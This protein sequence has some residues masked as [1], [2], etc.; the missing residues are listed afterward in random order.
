M[1]TMKQP[2]RIAQGHWCDLAAPAKINTFLHVI[3]KRGDGMHLLQSIFMM[4]DWGDYVDIEVTNASC[5]A[6]TDHANTAL[7]LPANDLC[8]QAATLL[9]Q[10]T[11]TTLGARIAL[12]K[13]LPAQAGLGG[14]SSDAAT[15]LLALNQLWHTGLNTDQLC[16]LAVQLG[17]DVPFF[18][19]GHNA[20]VQGIGEHITPIDLP[21]THVWVIKPQAGVATPDL[22]RAPDL[23]RNTPAISLSALQGLTPQALWAYG[24]NDLQPV[25]Q[26]LCPDVASACDW[27]TRQG[28]VPRMSGSGSAVFAHFSTSDF[29]TQAQPE[30][31][32]SGWLS[33]KCKNL[34]KHPLADWISPKSVG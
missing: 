13:H 15:C 27:L 14:G 19:R 30:G 21:Q 28:L 29:N 2:Q 32:P 10:A 4:L 18:V 23:T 12:H 1:R 20:F 31:L 16:N 26:Q 11:G 5:I 3:G 6:R 24:H 25:A 9:Q 34:R 22:F 33:H 17:A 7:Q 8:V